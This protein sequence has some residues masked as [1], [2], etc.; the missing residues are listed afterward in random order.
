VLA[1]DSNYI[2][3]CSE[4]F[5]TKYKHLYND[6]IT[7]SKISLDTLFPDIVGFNEEELSNGV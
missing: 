3:N 1:D 4:S 6:I 7:D 2:V 5:C